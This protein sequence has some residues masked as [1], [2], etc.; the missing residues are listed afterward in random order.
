MPDSRPSSPPVTI[1]AIRDA[2]ARLA[3]R[4]ERTPMRHS[5]ALSKAT[6]LDVWVKYENQQLTGAFKERGA[7]NRLLQLNESEKKRGVICASAGNHAQAL[8]QHARALGIPAT[9]VMPRGTPNVKVEQT[10]ARGAAIVIEGDT[11]DDAYAHAIKLRDAQNLVL[12]HPFDD[13]WVIA[14][15]GT[16]ALEMLE[17]APDLDVLVIPI[18]G[19]G[20]IA[21]MAVAAKAVKPGI[22]IVGVEAEMY[23][24]FAS[25]SNG[26][27]CKASGQTI[28]EGIAV[29]AVGELPFE[30]ARPLID[31]IVLIGEPMF[32]QAIALYVTAEKTIAEGAGA[33]TLA[34]LLAAPEKFQGQ[35]VGIILSGGNID[36]RLLAS[37]LERS[38][39][40][41]GR[42]AVLR[43]I[44][45]DRPGILAT[46]S[47]IIGDHGGNIL[48]VEHHRMTLA[49][50]IKGV[51]FDIEI[52]TRDAQHTGEI[53]A[54]L[55]DAGY[56]ARCL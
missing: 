25:R 54:A 40:R 2:A 37:V 38:L 15:Q 29:K 33:A 7:L 11:F 44:G 6:G 23:P 43:F 20:L 48:Q 51:E 14:G 56:E 8:A 41:E 17:D 50:P 47:R 24:S 4:I 32:E 45:D 16:A 26:E 1:D 9:I 49:A 19:G 5:R 36:T 35:K 30:I 42:I 18:G 28:A 46:V 27:Q 22:R 53:V 21:G 39:V 31:E 12:V 10:R 3:G 52:E 13:A 55:T 34:A